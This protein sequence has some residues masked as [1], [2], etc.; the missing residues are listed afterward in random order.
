VRRRVIFSADDF[1]L[2]EAVNEG[3]E[4][5]HRSGL[6]GSASLMV[7]GAAAADA[8]RRARTMPDLRVG[9]HVVAIEGPSVLPVWKIPDLV[10]ASGQFPSDQLRLG[11]RY[12]FLPSV[13][14]QL[15]AEIAAQFA[16]FAA[17]GLEL[18]HADAHKHMH[19]HP[20]VGAMII[21]AGWSYGLRAIRIPCEPVDVMQACGVKA[22]F[23]ARAMQA[24]SGLLRRQAEHVGLVVNDQV[25]GL[26]WSGGMTADRLLR[27]AEHLPEG[28]SEI[29]FHPSAGRDA[30]LDRLMPDYEH[31]AELAALCNPAVRAAFEKFDL[32]GY[33]DL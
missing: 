21:E 16:A 27:L 4:R 33:G 17:T 2:S 25:F 24:W 7:S 11:L 8:V 3:I 12:F 6:L 18:D 1:G 10:D 31:E 23:G 28:V 9:L 30:T 20:T 19:L 15:R 14:Q 22:S 13:R 5:A 32:I 26:S 29:Y